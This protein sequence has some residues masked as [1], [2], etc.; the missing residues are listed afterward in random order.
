MRWILKIDGREVGPLDAR[1]V[2]EYVAE[3]RLRAT[4]HIR[5][6]VD[7]RWRPAS[8]I[9]GFEEAFA[10]AVEG[11]PPPQPSGAPTHD[12]FVSHSHKDK[13]V[14]DALV[15]VLEKRGLRCWIARRDI[16][17][18]SNWSSSI[19]AGLQ[20][21]RALVLIFSKH[22]NASCRGVVLF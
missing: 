20:E 22:S 18:G 4:D 19:I 5:P 8:N 9:R 17:P 16:L 14:A 2:R 6:E 13:E 21:C 15:H 7:E 10:S 1:E 3:G 12:V 11:E